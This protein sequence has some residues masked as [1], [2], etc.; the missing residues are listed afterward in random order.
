MF[1]L[2]MMTE[3]GYCTGIENYSRYLSGRAPGEPPP[4]LFDY[5]PPDALLVVDESHVTIP[6]LGAMYK[7]DRSRKE[8][9]VEYGFRL[10]SALDNRPLQVRRVGALRAADDLRLGDAGPVRSARMPAQVVEQV[11]R[12]TGLVDPGGRDPAGRARRST[13]CCRRST[14]ASRA[15][16][17]VLV[18]TLTKRMAEDLTEYLHEHG[19][20]GALPALGHRDR[21]ARGDHPRP[22]ARQVRRAGRHQPAA[23]GPRHARGVAGGDPRCRQGRLPA[24]GRLAD[25]DH[26][27]RGAQPERQG[28]PVCRPR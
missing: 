4:C 28:D 2:E 12:P 10:P 6:Q 5:L 19:V 3:V 26:R 22:A 11:V 18:T 1:D 14:C 7:G 8:T 21:R 16:E 20:Q 17:R 25:P 9:L 27:P 13:T 15:D 23:R 24:L